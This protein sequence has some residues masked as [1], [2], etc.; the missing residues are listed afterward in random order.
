MKVAARTARFLPEF[1]SLVREGVQSVVIPVEGVAKARESSMFFRNDEQLFLLQELFRFLNRD[2]DPD[3]FRTVIFTCDTLQFG[4]S[5]QNLE[6][7]NWYIDT[8]EFEKIRKNMCSPDQDKDG[9]LRNAL[10][11]EG[12][13]RWWDSRTRS[14]R[15]AETSEAGAS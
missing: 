9:R 15:A 12:V 4:Q 2:T 13:K 6:T 3:F 14:A 1:V 11:L 5:S 7:L 10:R 8:Q